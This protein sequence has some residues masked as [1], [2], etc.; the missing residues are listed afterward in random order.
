MLSIE[1]IHG[2]LTNNNICVCVVCAMEIDETASSLYTEFYFVHRQIIVWL[3]QRHVPVAS[4]QMNALAFE[5][6]K[7]KSPETASQ[8]CDC[9]TLF[10]RIYNAAAFTYTD[11]TI[12]QGPVH[13][14]PN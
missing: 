2:G 10:T 8:F 14:W 9:T 5:T 4:H 13:C 3:S 11:D 6:I 1:Q 7:I 12:A